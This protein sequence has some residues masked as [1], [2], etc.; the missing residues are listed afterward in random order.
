MRMRVHSLTVG[1]FQSN[2]HIAACEETGKAVIFDACD[3]AARILDLVEREKLDVT[4][5]VNTHAHLDHIGALAQVKSALG[6]PVV[7]HEKELPVYEAT[8]QQAAMF[9]LHAP[10]VPAIDRFIK[11]GDRIEVG[12]STGVV[13]ETPGHSPGGVIIF[14]AGEQPPVAIVGDVIFRGSIGRTDL[15]GADHGEMIDTLRD[16]IIQ[17]PD[18]TIVYSGHGPDTTIALEKRSNPFLVDLQ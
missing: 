15:F 7:M 10:E 1:P 9:G 13:R 17:L 4:L 18:D 16:V 11:E 12:N 14:F 6:V 5:I 3:E 8:P 2:C